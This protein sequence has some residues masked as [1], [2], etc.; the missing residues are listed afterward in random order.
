MVPDRTPGRR[1]V[2]RGLASAGLLPVAGCSAGDTDPSIDVPTD[3]L[4][5]ESVAIGVDGL[6]PQSSV[7]LRASAES[8]DGTTWKSRAR[9][10]VGEAGRLSVP[11]RAPTEG[12]Y[13]G[14]DAMGP[15]WSMRP[16]DA[17]SSGPLPPETLFAPEES[18]YD[19]DLAAEVGGE[20]V[21]EATTTRRLFDPDIERRSVDH[22][23]L[24][25]RCFVPPG[26]GPAPGVIH[27]HGA[28]GRPH[29]ATGRLLASRG[30]AALV[31][32]YFGDPEPL[33]DGLAEVPVEYVETA[34]EWLR[35]R[36][37]VTGRVGLV[38]FSRGGTLALLAG[39]R[40]AD[41]GAVVGWVPSGVVW[42]GLTPGMRPAGTSAWSVDGDPVPYLGMA[43][44][45]P[46]PPPNPGL[47]YFEPALSAASE[48]ELGAASVPVEGTDAPVQLV[49][50]TDDAR[51]P[52]TRLSERVTERLDARE[53][54]HEYRHDRYAGGGHYLRLPYLPT[55]GTVRDRYRVYGGAPAAN[56]RANAGAWAGTL[57][58]LDAALGDQ[59]QRTGRRPWWPTRE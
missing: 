51:W 22:P 44:H 50:A 55:P 3:A 10:E 12:T 6:E 27:L 57:S 46:G 43:E 56:A 23:D 49:S 5:D 29:L 34:V 19:V 42:E 58:F 31:L 9:F 48:D 33:P 45:E 40:C 18:G 30:Y 20:T 4:T 15:F 53:F 13:E 47:P 39:S 52:S 7:L 26:D 36:D 24:V 11:D 16:L 37:R 17:G 21:A 38:G 8:R 14:A 35:E 41:V 2:L 25:G 54:P 59:S 32:H 1:D 28:G